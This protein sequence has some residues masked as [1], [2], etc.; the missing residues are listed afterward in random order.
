LRRA[1]I[2]DKALTMHSFRHT[3]RTLAREIDMPEAV[4]R[5]LMGHSLGK[6]DHSAYGAVP[7][8][9][10]RAAWMARMKILDD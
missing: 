9:K 2:A 4:S 7:S 6:D 1:G 8:L 3:W 10:V 5:S